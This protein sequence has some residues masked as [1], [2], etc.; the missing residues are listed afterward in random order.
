MSRTE[1]RMTAFSLQGGG[2]DVGSPSSAQ[3]RSLDRGGASRQK[4]EPLPLI[5]ARAR[6]ELPSSRKESEINF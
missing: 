2:T 5:K 1:A 3:R 4:P 6:V